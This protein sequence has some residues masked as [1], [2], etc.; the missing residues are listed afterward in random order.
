MLHTEYYKDGTPCECDEMHR[1]D[2]AS[3]ALWQEIPYVN[4]ERHGS[5]REYFESGALSWVAPYVNGKEHGIEKGYYKSGVLASE[6]PYEKGRSHGI[7]Q[8]YKENGSF[9]Y[10]YVFVHGTYFP[11]VA[12]PMEHFL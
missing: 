6:I 12:C 3:G 2:F 11:L 4:G 5:I 10:A 1:V 8:S 7:E 9:I